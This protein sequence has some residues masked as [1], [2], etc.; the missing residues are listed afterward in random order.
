MDG[1][2]EA[3][4]DKREVMHPTAGAS[5]AGTGHQALLECAGHPFD[6]AVALRVI[7]SSLRSGLTEQSCK[8]APQAGRE[9]ASS[10][11]DDGCRHSEPGNPVLKKGAGQASAV[12]E[13]RGMALT[14]QEKWRW[15]GGRKNPRKG[16]SGPTKLRWRAVKR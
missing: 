16:G 3:K 6:E 14:H 9:L 13:E 12:M 15:R 8:L 7:G 5:G 4:Q 10:I 2:P 1:C 11:C